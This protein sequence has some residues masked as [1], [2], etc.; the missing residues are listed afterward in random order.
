M[1]ARILS[2]CTGE[3]GCYIGLD[4]L[5]SYTMRTNR[6]KG[7]LQTLLIKST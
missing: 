3:F 1:R 7:D 4:I 6:C 5:G 2:R